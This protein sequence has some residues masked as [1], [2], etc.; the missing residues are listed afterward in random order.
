M[1]IP[2]TI[3]RAGPS[4][5]GWHV[6]ALGSSSLRRNQSASELACVGLERP[7]IH[8]RERFDPEGG[9]VRKWV[10]EPRPEPLVDLR[11]SREAALDAYVEMRR[12]ASTTSRK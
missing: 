4:R 6:R 8:P 10:T 2:R 11:R 3:P 1:T 5:D 7:R 9:Y 12:R